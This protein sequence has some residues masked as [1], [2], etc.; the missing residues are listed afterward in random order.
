VH[1][2]CNARSGATWV[3]SADVKE[4]LQHELAHAWDWA[5]LSEPTRQRFL[6]MQRLTRW[7][8]NIEEWRRLGC[9]QAAEIVAWG[10]MDEALGPLTDRL[11]SIFAMRAEDLPVAFRLLTGRAPLHG[12]VATEGS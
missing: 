6:V 7:R 2:D 10:L 3:P 9:E 4:V 5:N 11:T 12:P 1:L 8:G